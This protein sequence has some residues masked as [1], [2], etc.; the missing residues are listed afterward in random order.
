[1]TIPH[2]AVGILPRWRIYWGPDIAAGPGK[3][4]LLDRIKETGSMLEAAKRM[5]MS[6]MRAWLLVKTMNRCFRKPL[7][8]R[9][10]G[11]RRGGGTK[12]TATG[13]RLLAL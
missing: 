7:V 2:K 10:R 1:M 4:E 8:I 3:I 6:Y 11:G 9:T 12:L 13:Q 5:N